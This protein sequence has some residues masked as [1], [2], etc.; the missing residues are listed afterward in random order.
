MLPEQGLHRRGLGRHRRG[1]TVQLHQEDGAGIGGVTR[2][3]DRSLHCP[4]ACL[5][6]QL[7]CRRDDPGRNDGAHRLARVPH[8]GEVGKQGAHRER[9]GDQ[10]HGDLQRNAEHPLRTHEEPD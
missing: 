9:Q 5:V 3:V 8:R 7:Q 4:D 1:L 2:G 10:P 6:Q